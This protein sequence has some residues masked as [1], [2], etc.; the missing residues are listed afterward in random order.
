MRA[1]FV[2]L[3]PDR[4][5]IA[6]EKF[7]IRVDDTVAVGT[8]RCS[9]FPAQPGLSHPAGARVAE[10]T[11]ARIERFAEEDSMASTSR[12]PRARAAIAT[13]D[14]VRRWW[15]RHAVRRL[16]LPQ[17]NAIVLAVLRSRAHRLLSATAIEL[18]YIGR[19][20]GREFVLPVQYAQMGEQLVVRPQHWQRATWWRNFRTP[21][22][23]TVRLAG[24]LRDG[25]AQVVETSDPRWGL[26]RQAY[27]T[28]WPRS[29]PRVTGPLV[30]IDLQP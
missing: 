19:R 23:V 3:P 29:T 25:T 7:E 17:G 5:R 9:S 8:R 28:R 26:A 11:R 12:T 22:P 6:G 4:C 20:S 13:V 18:R 10:E 15:R 2:G 27:M 24:R 14:R 1:E 16:E 30:V 21:Q